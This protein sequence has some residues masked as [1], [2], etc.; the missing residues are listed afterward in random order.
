MSDQLKVT[1]GACIGWVSATWPFAK[2][3][4]S[5]EQLSVSGNLI[6]S[7][8]FSPD[9]VAALEPCGSI[10]IVSSGVR[11]IHTVQSYPEEMIFWCFGSSERLIRQ[12]TDLG[13]MPS[14]SLAEVPHR[15]GMAFR[16]PFVL[17]EV[18]V[19]N[20]LL[21]A[22][23][24]APWQPSKWPGLYTLSAI[25]LLFLTA[26]GLNFSRRFQSLALKPGRSLSEVR[27]VAILVLVISAIMLL[28]FLAQYVAR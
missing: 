10:P 2:L 21:L 16:W 7:Y 14:A 23:G 9:Q 25:A 17:L 19:W 26:V 27:A 11:I 28:V 6:G 15:N 12:I 3:S 8:T 22:D 13:F 18:A 4:A 5:A 20:A 1:G 24:F